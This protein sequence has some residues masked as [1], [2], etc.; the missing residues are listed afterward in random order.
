VRADK[1]EHAPH[2]ERFLD[3]S[4]DEGEIEGVPASAV[5]GVGGEDGSDDEEREEEEEAVDGAVEREEKA[6]R[7]RIYADVETQMDPDTLDLTANV[8]V[9]EKVIEGSNDVESFIYTGSDAMEKFTR[10]CL[11]KDSPFKNSYVCLHN[12]HRFDVP[13]WLVVLHPTEMMIHVVKC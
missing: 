6:P 9:L 11:K 8:V 13:L 12:G 3:P 7:A 5:A 4:D 10:D 2:N 1:G